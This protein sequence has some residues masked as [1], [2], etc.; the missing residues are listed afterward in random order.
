MGTVT[1]LQALAALATALGLG[2]VVPPLVKGLVAHWTGRAERERTRIQQAEH[3]RSRADER[4]SQAIARA[5]EWREYAHVLRAQLIEQCGVPP[6]QLP[7]RPTD[8]P[9]RPDPPDDGQPTDVD[10]APPG[11]TP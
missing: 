11:G 8:P 3:D 5:H 4:A 2:T 6:S 9:R 10:H 1:V 7:P